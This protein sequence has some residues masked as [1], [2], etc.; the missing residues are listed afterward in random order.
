LGDIEYKSE[1]LCRTV[2]PLRCLISC[3]H[4]RLLVTCQFLEE[5]V[6]F[7]TAGIETGHKRWCFCCWIVRF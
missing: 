7:F 3:K 5:N 2:L 6:S 4:M 1:I